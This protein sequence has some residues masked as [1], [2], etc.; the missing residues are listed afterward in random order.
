M[1][2]KLLFIILFTSS[3][4]GFTQIIDSNNFDALDIGIFSDGS[5]PGQG[6]FLVSGNNGEA[7]TTTDNIGAGNAQ[8]VASG[9]NGTQGAQLIT[10]NGDKGIFF[11]Y[12]P[13]TSE[14]ATRASGNDIIELELSFFTGAATTSTA[15]FRATIFGTNGT[16]NFPIVSLTFNP[17]NNELRGNATINV[18][19]EDGYYFFNLGP[20]NTELILPANTWFDVACSYNPATGLLLWGT[21]F[22][23]TQV[24]FNNP[25]NIITGLEPIELDFLSFALDTNTSAAT[26]LFDDYKIFA[27]NE[28]GLNLLSDNSGDLELEA[29]N[30]TLF[31]NPANNSI[32]LKTNLSIKEVTVTNTLGQIVLTKKA[33]FSRT[34]EFDI[35]GFNAGLYVMSI[36]SSDGN[37]QTRKFLKK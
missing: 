23:E 28:D 10:P 17:I 13:I 14:W 34:N 31:P 3:L 8:V 18:N 24:F 2:T 16:D 19:G 1:K 25:D 29:T 22:N 30:L 15:P 5:G 12:K 20:S 32:T 35:S 26:Y 9:E 21:S 7:P 37:T 36:K 4:V 33:D 11:L 27:K 6:G